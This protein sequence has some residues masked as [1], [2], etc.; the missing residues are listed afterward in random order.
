MDLFGQG[1]ARDDLGRLLDGK[2]PPKRR[3]GRPKDAPNRRALDWVKWLEATGELPQHMLARY[4]RADPLRLVELGIAP[5][6]GEAMKPDI[7]ADDGQ[8]DRKTIPTRRISD[9]RYRTM[10]KKRI[11]NRV[12]TLVR[13]LI[14]DQR[15]GRLL[16]FVGGWFGGN[17]RGRRTGLNWLGPPPT[18]RAPHPP[19][20]GSVSFT[21]GMPCDPMCFVI[22]SVRFCSCR[23]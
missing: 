1:E 15:A 2:G 7:G 20:P 12:L 9:G 3:R 18:P 6:L 17:R 23:M 13:L 5:T 4:M 19:E 16:S 11:K 8:I 21:T 10:D 14:D 22:G